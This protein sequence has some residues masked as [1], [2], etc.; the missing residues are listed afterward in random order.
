MEQERDDGWDRP[1]PRPERDQ[2][3]KHAV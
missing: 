3:L 2:R 1:A